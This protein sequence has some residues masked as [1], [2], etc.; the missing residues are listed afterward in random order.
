[1]KTPSEYTREKKSFY[2]KLVV[3]DKQS[4]FCVIF[5][6]NFSLLYRNPA[7]FI[8]VL[9]SGAN[10]LQLMRTVLVKSQNQGLRS[11]VRLAW[12]PKLRNIKE[13]S[14]ELVHGLKE[15]QFA[16]CCQFLCNFK[17]CFDVSAYIT[18]CLAR[19]F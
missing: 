1:M 11:I 9:F 2:K 18:Q 12:D 14:T 6:K 4:A 16:K 3:T 13:Q 10:H 17:N 5:G 19:N 7:S 15:T 8:A